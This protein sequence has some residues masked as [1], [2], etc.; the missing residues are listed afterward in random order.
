M[1]PKR[2][3]VYDTNQAGDLPRIHEV[4][5]QLFDDG[6]EPLVK[7]Y[8]LFSDKPPEPDMPMEHALRFLVDEKFQVIDPSGK[9]I[10][11]PPKVEGGTGA[12][13]LPDNQTIANWDELSRAALFKRCKVIP[14]SE[15]IKPTD[16]PEVFV[17]FLL[18]W[19]RAQK[20]GAGGIA[21]HLAESEEQMTALTK[22]GELDGQTSQSDLRRLFPEDSP[23]LAKVA[24]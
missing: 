15:A 11:P 5:T 8:K 13:V 14:G 3:T 6:R 20:K 18:G 22:G 24:G 1:E 7:K 17:E 23:L 2:W 4:I 16:E 9:R 12:Y 21:S 19:Q 10:T